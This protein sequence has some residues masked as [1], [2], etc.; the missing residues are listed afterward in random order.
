MGAA[1]GSRATPHEVDR[2]ASSRG[3]P[4][5]RKKPTQDA[6]QKWYENSEEEGESLEKKLDFADDSDDDCDEAMEAGEVVVISDDEGPMREQASEP[7]AV[8]SP[9]VQQPPAQLRSNGLLFASESRFGPFEGLGK[10]G[11]GKIAVVRL[12]EICRPSYLLSYS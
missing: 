12:S 8:A 7:E 11:L 5:S 1:S 10:R 2:F 3:F 9:T 4:L 6:G